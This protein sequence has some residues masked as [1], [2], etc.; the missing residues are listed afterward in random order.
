MEKI[1]EN[2]I[3]RL[4]NPQNIR[5]AQVYVI[6]LLLSG[7]IWF[8][9]SL[10][11]D[12]TDTLSIS[13]KYKDLPKDWV[14]VS[15]P[16]ASINVE[17]RSHGL[18]ILAE[19]YLG[20]G[21][22]LKVDIPVH[23]NQAKKSLDTRSLKEDVQRLL[24]ST[25]EIIDIQPDTLFFDLDR[26]GSKRMKLS[27]NCQLSARAG[28]QVEHYS[29]SAQS[30]LARGPSKGLDTLAL[31]ETHPV[32]L[33]DLTHSDSTLVTLDLP[34][35]LSTDQSDIYLRYQVDQLIEGSITLPLPVIK[36]ADRAIL[37]TF[38]RKV[39]LSYS[40]GLSHFDQINPEDF[41]IAIDTTAVD[42]EQQSKLR[43]LISKSPEY[44]HHLSTNPD[45]VEFVIMEDFEE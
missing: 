17:L 43:V 3:E 36:L 8:F 20:F 5:R 16:P 11:E 32:I 22:T 41:A 6:C 7:S 26:L 25:T 9:R 14:L 45:K 12:Y 1:R 44:I 34:A 23:N 21:H 37:R 19:K 31:L 30:I 42:F 29:L 15:A 24:G 18:S 13:L 27:P 35:G 4:R 39:T 38:P 28:S 40:V 2:L 33:N 10:T